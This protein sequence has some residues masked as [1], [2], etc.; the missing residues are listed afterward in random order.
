VKTEIFA[1]WLSE[2][3]QRTYQI[4]YDYFGKG[5]IILEPHELAIW[6]NHMSD[7]TY[8]KQMLDNLKISVGNLSRGY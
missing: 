8:Q 6:K 4:C 3:L 5:N 1:S 7:P 2:I